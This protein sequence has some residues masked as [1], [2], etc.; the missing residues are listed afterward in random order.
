MIHILT[1]DSKDGFQFCKLIKALYFDDVFEDISLDTMK[2]IPN[3]VEK[4]REKHNVMRDGDIT[5]IVYDDIKE[6]PI[7]SKA[8]EEAA[9]YIEKNHLDERVLWVSTYSFEIELLLVIGFEFF[10]NRNKYNIYFRGLRDKFIETEKLHDLTILSKKNPL[11]TEMYNKVRADKLKKGMYKCLSKEDFERT[12]TIESISKRIMTEV[13]KYD[14][15]AKATDY[16]DKPVGN[17]DTCNCW[18]NNCC[19]KG[20]RCKNDCIDFD[21]IMKKQEAEELYKTKFL[22]LNTSY[23]KLITAI[24]KMK[25]TEIELPEITIGDLVHPETLE[26]NYLYQQFTSQKEVN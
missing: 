22:I 8:I 19:S 12:M 9:E 18:K 24:Y 25:E 10:A 3:V 13:F 5:I 1:E 15:P 2:G 16:V 26:A 17:A 14:S 4:I 7:V 21:I 11:Y 20:K 23:K 6:N